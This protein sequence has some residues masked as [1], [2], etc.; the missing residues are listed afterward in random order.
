MGW[1]TLKEHF[2]IGHHVRIEEGSLKI[3]SQFVSDLAVIDCLTG[4]VQS[5]RVFPTFLSDQYP[6]LLAASSQEIL[7]LLAVPDIFSSSITVFTYDGSSIIEKQCSILG[8]PNTT[9]DGCMMFDNKYSPDKSVVVS[10]AKNSA[11]TSIENR[12]ERIARLQ[13]EVAET[14]ADLSFYKAIRF[15]LETDYP[16]DSLVSEG[17]HNG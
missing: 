1:Q 2:G 4:V 6:A 10:W 5:N 3:G 15:K 13:N 8:Y 17:T 12:T 7:G 11:F 9:H 14:E 16:S